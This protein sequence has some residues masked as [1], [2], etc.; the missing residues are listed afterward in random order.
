MIRAV[1][2]RAYPKIGYDSDVDHWQFDFSLVD[3]N[4]VVLY[5]TIDMATVRTLSQ[6]HSVGSIQAMCR[7]ILKTALCDFHALTGQEFISE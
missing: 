7:A 2:K 6:K 5:D 1:L 3:T 4:G